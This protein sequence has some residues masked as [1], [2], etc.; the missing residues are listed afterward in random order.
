MSI[1]FIGQTSVYETDIMFFTQCDATTY[2]LDIWCM[3]LL[4]FPYFEDC[5]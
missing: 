4:H 2:F 1:M 5:I 3:Y